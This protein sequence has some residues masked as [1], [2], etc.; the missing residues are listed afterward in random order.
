MLVSGVTDDKRDPLVG[1]SAAPGRQADCK[2]QR[3]RDRVFDQRIHAA[4]CAAPARFNLRVQE[5]NER[6]ATAEKVTAEA[7][8]IYSQF[9]YRHSLSIVARFR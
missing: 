3:Q 7:S 5:T 6:K 1:A 9:P 4:A 8:K 2:R